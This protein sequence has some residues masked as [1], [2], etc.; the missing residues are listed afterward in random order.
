MIVGSPHSTAPIFHVSTIPTSGVE[1]SSSRSKVQSQ[2]PTVDVKSVRSV[3]IVPDEDTT[4][5]RQEPTKM[6][7]SFSLVPY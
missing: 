4:D 7:D 5:T 1:D 3:Y 6:C 2:H